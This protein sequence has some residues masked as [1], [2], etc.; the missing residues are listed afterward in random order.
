MK[1]YGIKLGSMLFSMVEPH[2]GHEVDYNRW[3]ERD[4]FYAGC[5]IGPFNL[6]GGRWVAT[7]LYKDLRYPVSSPIT[8]DPLVGSYLALYWI[9]KGHHDE[10]NRWGVDQVNWL[11]ANGRM[12][13]ERDHIHTLLYDFD[14]GVQRDPDGVSPELALDHRYPGLVVIVGE[15]NAGSDRDKLGAWYR[16][17]HLPRRLAGSAVDQC[18]SFSPLPLLA[19]APGDVPRTEGADRRFVH[20]YFIDTDPAELWQEHFAGHGAQL[21][22]TGLGRLLW[23][24][25]FIP[26]IVGSDTYT[27]QLR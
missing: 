19:D 16:H 13:P 25:P 22:A 12:F 7:R 6:S 20:L 11:H 4:H 27:D 14:W 21:E 9:E 17:E 10:W 2:A 5:M 18:L 3:Y 8:P 26:T 15:V 1:E 24:S 23:A